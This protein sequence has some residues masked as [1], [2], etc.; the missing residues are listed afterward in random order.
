MSPEVQYY[1]YYYRCIT[2]RG[3]SSPRSTEGTQSWPYKGFR[4]Q[5]SRAQVTDSHHTYA[6]CVLCVLADIKAHHHRACRIEPHT[7]SAGFW[8]L[9]AA[10]SVAPAV[11]SE[12]GRCDAAT[13]RAGAT[14]ARKAE[15]G[16]APAHHHRHHH[17]HSHLSLP[18]SPE[19]G[20]PLPGFGS[21]FGSWLLASYYY[22]LQP[23]G[24]TS[25]ADPR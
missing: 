14:P 10:I 8:L 24:R 16:L 3:G 19:P 7:H 21:A 18:L 20:R 25:P 17:R 2:G 23:L 13:V 22:R 12:A 6:C 11:G 5:R 1:Y 15:A 4:W 9:A